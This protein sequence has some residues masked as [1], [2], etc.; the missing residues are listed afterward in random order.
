[1]TIPA[2][3]VRFRFFLAFGLVVIVLWAAIA[4]VL[5]AAHHQTINRASAE[6]RNLARSLAEHV[7]SSVRAIDIT[8]QH[9]R[10]EWIRDP[11][12]FAAA[13][14]RKQEIL[15]DQSVTQVL[16]F[17]ANG[18]TI[19][20]SLPTWQPIDVSD[21]SYFTVHKERAT[22][23]LDISEPVV[24]RVTKQWTIRFTRPVFDR[25]KQ[26]AGV[27]VF[28][29]PPPAL[30]RIYHDI[31]LRDG[32]II[33]LARSDGQILAHSRDLTKAAAVLLSDTPG[34]APD[35]P[36][37]GEFRRKA[38]IDGVERFYAY[39][40]VGR[41]PLT[42]FVGQAADT[43]L[44][45]YHAQR[46]NY[47]ISGIVTTAL[48]LAVTLL[49]ISRSE[50]RG[51]ESAER[52]RSQIA[53]IV[54]NSNDAIVGRDLDR[55]IVIWNAAAERLL[56]WTA[57]EAIGQDLTQMFPPEEQPKIMANRARVTQGG[58]TVAHEAV[59]ITKDGRRIDVS[60]GV[61][62]IKDDRGKIIGSAAIFRDLTERKQ[63]EARIQHLAHHDTLTDLPNRL[64]F[65]DRLNHAISLSKR[66]R[67]ELALLYVDLDKFKAVN[68]TLGHDAG[69]ELLKRVADRIRRELRESDTLARMGGDEFAV[70]LPAITSREDVAKVAGKI[71]GALS[72]NFKLSG[73]AQEVTIGASMGIA[74][75]PAD[76]QD[77]DTLIKA[78]DT[79]M[80]D[81]KHVGNNFRFCKA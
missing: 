72:T 5:N 33:A 31:E 43:V 42:V 80:Y 19:Y 6:R 7:A 35:S 32:G 18:R 77:L 54:E 65:Y 51:K 10:D 24:G 8:L 1:M 28:A 29:V 41:Y 4:L 73:H 49:L 34:L 47:L 81:A 27:L 22:D 45:P 38:K 13:I 75:Y 60:L 20:G 30:E 63:A 12:S 70:I 55:K 26:F 68:D 36:A 53:T 37:T 64:L 57:A 23:A 59:R 46:T 15:K 76:A 48:L 9:L 2:R 17:G 67:N 25:R 50:R 74:I 11:A 16:V 44:A 58:G 52:V 14:A 21:R 69:D 3:S 40:K 39:H 78:A 79:A 62:P 56:G 61:S 66:D 71:V